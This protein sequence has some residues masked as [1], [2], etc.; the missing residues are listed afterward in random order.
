M[1]KEFYN[2]VGR[3]KN[4]TARVYLSDGKGNFSINNVS[5]DINNYLKRESL[6]IHA[7]KPLEVLNLKGKYDIK[8]NVKGGGLTGQAGAIQLGIARALL[9][10][11][12]EFRSQ[13]KSHGLLT[14]DAREVERKKIW[15]TWS[16]KEVPIFKKI[17]L[18]KKLLKKTY[19]IQV[20]ISA[21]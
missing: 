3:R 5:D 1:K 21:M 14:R 6:V 4:S 9:K 12:D 18:C 15:T 19:L 11:D 20:H 13:L 2:G 17:I 8:I 16:K 10:I 7:V